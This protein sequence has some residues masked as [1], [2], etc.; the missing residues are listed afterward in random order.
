MVELFLVIS[1]LVMVGLLG[2]MTTMLTP[3][4]MLETGI[5]TLLLGLII[6]LPAGLWYHILLYRALAQRVPLPPNW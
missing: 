1:A 3:Q 5:W 2:Q 6:G 4:V